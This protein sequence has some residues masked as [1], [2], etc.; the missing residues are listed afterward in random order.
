MCN[1]HDNSN[2]PDS[3]AIYWDSV[4][5]VR[6]QYSPI[7]GKYV[8]KRIS[9]WDADNPK[10][11]P[12][13][14][15][16][17]QEHLDKMNKSIL[18]KEENQSTNSQSISSLNQN[19]PI[20]KMSN[21]NYSYNNKPG[22]MYNNYS[23]PIDTV[24]LAQKSPYLNRN[25]N[26]SRSKTIPS[27]M[28]ELLGK[29]V[30][31][32]SQNKYGE[33]I[34]NT[35]TPKGYYIEYSPSNKHPGGVPIGKGVITYSTQTP[36]LSQQNEELIHTGQVDFYK[37]NR[38]DVF[39][40]IPLINLE[41]EAKVLEDIIVRINENLGIYNTIDESI[42]MPG[43]KIFM[44]SDSNSINKNLYG[45]YD[46]MINRVAENGY[47]S[48]QDLEIYYKVGKFMSSEKSRDERVFDESIPPSFLLYILS[49]N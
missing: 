7:W 38:K 15:P 33:K 36:Q 6:M 48:S 43:G 26:F 9:V 24:N 47:F 20:V 13:N 31:Y 46:K 30:D 34:L 45:E 2:E 22:V 39:K 28:W 49:D 25:F 8:E 27:D 21:K 17:F 11:Q 10:Y 35:V 40:N 44:G 37:K 3:N 42:N 32:L 29:G 4:N 14:L 41:F 12:Q 5:N 16:N 23:Q 1:F 18:S 19:A